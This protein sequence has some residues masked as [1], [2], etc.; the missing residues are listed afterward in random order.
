MEQETTIED[1]LTDRHRFKNPAS[2]AEKASNSALDLLEELEGAPKRQIV[3]ILKAKAAYKLALAC[4]VYSSDDPRTLPTEDLLFLV[5]SSRGDSI[6]DK[7]RARIASPLTALRA[8]CV[9][10]QGG[11]VAFV[12]ECPS[13]NCP[14]WAFRMGNNPFYNRMPD[15]DAE[16]EDP[17]VEEPTTPADRE[18][19][20]G[21]S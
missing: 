1:W 10:C 6:V 11:G 12:R 9:E 4:A 21:N 19:D 7:Y 8:Y 17:I 5:Q 3:Q 14:I 15:A 20:D 2:V 16:S 13:T 18:D